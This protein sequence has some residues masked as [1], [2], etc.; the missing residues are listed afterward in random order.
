MN[1]KGRILLRKEIIVNVWKVFSV[2]TGIIEKD[3]DLLISNIVSFYEKYDNPDLKKKYL[4]ITIG[5]A[6]DDKKLRD[7]L[8]CGNKFHYGSTETTSNLLCF[9]AY[10]TDYKSVLKKHFQ[11]TIEKEKEESDKIKGCKPI[12]EFKNENNTSNIKDLGKSNGNYK[13]LFLPFQDIEKNKEASALRKIFIHRW[14]TNNDLL[15]LGLEIIYEPSITDYITYEEAKALGVLHQVNMVIWGYDISQEGT[16]PHTIFFNYVN[17]TEKNLSKIIPKEEGK[18]KN[19]KIDLLYK[20]FKDKEGSLELEIDDIIYWFL[21]SKFYLDCNYEKSLLALKKIKSK[22]YKN[23]NLH[24]YIANNYYFLN[25]FEKAKIYFEK[26]L[27]IK[28]DLTE[29]RCNYANLLDEGFNN[30]ES[31][32]EQ[33]KM[34]IENE[35]DLAEAHYNYACMLT[36]RFKDNYDLV[37]FHLKKAITLKDNFYE[38]HFLYADLLENK[39]NEINEARKHYE[40]AIEI[41]PDF[42]DAYLCL[43][44]LLEIRFNETDEAIKCYKKIFKIDSDS[45]FAHRN[46]AILLRKLNKN[47]EAEEHYKKALE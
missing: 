16:L 23:E 41:N 15:K 24:F 5:F 4:T 37:K 44:L 46:Y 35:P 8:T 43:A 25:L 18:T 2:N 28:P 20:L 21:G 32:K 10:N 26:A 27:K 42:E 12:T 33:Y 9:Y 34:I 6:K 14:K 30:I 31:A 38:A 1:F 17:I 7:A 19:V 3:Y 11:S 45:A 13:I 47:K 36:L 39:F 40:K 22:N 29:A